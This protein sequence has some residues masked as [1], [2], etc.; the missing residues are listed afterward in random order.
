MVASSFFGCSSNLITDCAFLDFVARL[1]SK[2]VL[3]NE[4]K[5]TSEPDTNADITNK[6][7]RATIPTIKDTF[8]VEISK[9]KL[10]GSGSNYVQF[11]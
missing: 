3:D 7:K 10:K 9:N 5:A 8:V 2:F 4:K 11:S 6:I 1:L